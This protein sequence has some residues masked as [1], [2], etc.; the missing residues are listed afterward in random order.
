MLLHKGFHITMI[1]IYKQLIPPPS[2]VMHRFT[3]INQMLRIL[4]MQRMQFFKLNR[5]TS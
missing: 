1:N 3:L 4:H 5:Q 2:D